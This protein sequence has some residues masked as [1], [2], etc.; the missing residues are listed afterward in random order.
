MLQ[1]DVMFVWTLLQED[2]DCCCVLFVVSADGDG[3][4]DWIFETIESLGAFAWV[5]D[6]SVV[7]CL[8]VCC[9]LLVPFWGDAT[10]VVVLGECIGAL[11]AAVVTTAV[12]TAAVLLLRAFSI[13]VLVV[14]VD[15]VAVV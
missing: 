2:C 4:L 14:V 5:V 1:C 10:E 15:V 11:P 3:V 7:V 9:W 13:V 12:H 8:F 6:L